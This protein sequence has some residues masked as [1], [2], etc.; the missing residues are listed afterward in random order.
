MLLN[1]GQLNSNGVLGFWSLSFWKVKK[2]FCN[3][4]IQREN[5]LKCF[6]KVNDLAGLTFC[7]NKHLHISNL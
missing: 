1:L 5:C 3:S 7:S 6:I 2:L 4:T